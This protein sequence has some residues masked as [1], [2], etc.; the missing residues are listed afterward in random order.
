MHTTPRQSPQH[1]RTGC[2]ESF[3]EPGAATGRQIR[4]L[5]NGTA[6]FAVVMAILR[7]FTSS[8]KGITYEPVDGRICVPSGEMACAR[9]HCAIFSCS[10]KR[11]AV[12][13]EAVRR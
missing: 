8:C 1:A 13:R 5:T 12:D 10:L 7:T 3:F 2:S 11:R 6:Y 9:R 4:Y